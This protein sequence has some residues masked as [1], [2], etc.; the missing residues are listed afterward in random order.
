M[1]IKV[2]KNWTVNI[3]KLLKNIDGVWRRKMSNNGCT[4]PNFTTSVATSWMQLLHT[5]NNNC[6]LNH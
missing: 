2:Q 3:H 4:Q 6:I 5:S 1:T